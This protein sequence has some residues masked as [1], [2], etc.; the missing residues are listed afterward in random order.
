MYFD[1]MIKLFFTS[2]SL[3]AIKLGNRCQLES[4]LAAYVDMY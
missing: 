4:F 3:F 1:K 2:Y